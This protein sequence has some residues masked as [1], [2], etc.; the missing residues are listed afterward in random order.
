MSTP[1]HLLRSAIALTATLVA[2][3]ALAPSATAD[4]PAERWLTFSSAMAE[5]WP[6]LQRENG[7]FRDYVTTRPNRYGDA[8]MGYA[9]IQTG[10]R[11]RDR[12][13]IN[14]GIRGIGRAVRNGRWRNSVSAFEVMAIA[15]SYRLGRTRLGSNDLFAS[16]RSVWADWLRKRAKIEEL[17]RSGYF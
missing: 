5:P 2:A 16:E 13:L 14:S 17:D 7:S 10:L 11:D 12:K 8:M 9:L 4:T 3:L 1:P 15:A 6:G